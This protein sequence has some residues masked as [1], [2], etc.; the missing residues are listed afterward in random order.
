MKNY[1]IIKAAAISELMEKW[2]IQG[3]MTGQMYPG[4]PSSIN[5][6]SRFE[7]PVK[8]SP[9]NI[10]GKTKK[11]RGES[12]REAQLF[13]NQVV[14]GDDRPVRADKVIADAAKPVAP[15]NLLG[16]TPAQ[17]GDAPRIP[18]ARPINED[19]MDSIE[20]E[21]RKISPVYEQRRI[22]QGKSPVVPDN[23]DYA[24]NPRIGNTGRPARAI[25]VDP[26]SL[27]T[28]NTK[29]NYEAWF[30]NNKGGAY[31]PNSKADYA[32]M[33]KLKTLGQEYQKQYGQDFDLGSEE[34][35]TR[36]MNLRRSLGMP[37][38]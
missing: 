1:N 13:E 33:A 15:R 22:A 18:N 27:V 24:V 31:N 7:E 19:N 8:D 21:A 17:R 12:P 36:M 14:L 38:R 32:E 34:A 29:T 20:F 28:P 23:A 2:A 26:L 35:K 30:R 9:I 16:Q 4:G 37:L 3:A 25:V 11:E 10:F 5:A 6:V